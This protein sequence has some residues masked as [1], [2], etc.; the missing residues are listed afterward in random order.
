MAK[1]KRAKR[2]KKAPTTR[3]AEKKEAFFENVEANIQLF[4]FAR[5]DGIPKGMRNNFRLCEGEI[6]RG[7]VQILPKG[8][9]NSLHYHPA[10][11]G[12]WMVLSG[13]VRFYGNDSNFLGEFGPMEGVLIPRNGR[14]W[15][16][17]AG[18]EEAHLLQVRGNAK[19]GS[20]N[21]V[22]VGEVHAGY[23]KKRIHNLPDAQE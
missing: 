18:D 16:A 15:F 23:G 8:F 22:D 1:A 14:Y 5:P 12:F 19:D 21:R 6:L 3:G 20:K 9:S 11:E 13:E 17:Q 10:S 2:A 7:T 4:S